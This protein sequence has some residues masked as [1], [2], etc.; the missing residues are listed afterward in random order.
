MLF[1]LAFPPKLSELGVSV[2]HF[3]TGSL[4]PVLREW[5]ELEGGECGVGD[6]QLIRVEGGGSMW[7][8]LDC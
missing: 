5:G 3:T 7:A 2:S 6:S 8:A 4:P 1:L